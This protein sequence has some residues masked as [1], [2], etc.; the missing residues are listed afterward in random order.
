M[1]TNVGAVAGTGDTPATGDT[2][3]T[4][5]CDLESYQY[6]SGGGGHDGGHDGGDYGGHD[7]DNGG[8]NGGTA[9]GERCNWRLKNLPRRG[10][11]VGSLNPG[12]QI[13][14]DTFWSN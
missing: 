6:G 10:R 9:D 7:G 1:H 14:Q 4:F 3:S 11:G 13:R 12:I 8:D 2:A 5:Y